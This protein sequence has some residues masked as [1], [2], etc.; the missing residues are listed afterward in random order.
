MRKSSPG[1]K[2]D[3]SRFVTTNEKRDHE[4]QGEQMGGLEGGNKII[5]KNLLNASYQVAF[6]VKRS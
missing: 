6:E 5:F 1:K 3:L 2:T 4:T